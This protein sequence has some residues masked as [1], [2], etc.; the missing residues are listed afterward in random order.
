[1]HLLAAQ[2]GGFVEQEGIVDLAQSPAPLVVFSAAGTFCWIRS[3][4]F[5]ASK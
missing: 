2:P 4:G 5:A 1:M 3:S